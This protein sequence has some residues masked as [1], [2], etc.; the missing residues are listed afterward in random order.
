MH[1]ALLTGINLKAEI[2]DDK[3]L[4]LL[5]VFAHVIFQYLVVA[6]VVFDEDR[7]ELDSLTNKGA[8]S[9]R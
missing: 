4:G 1:D 6:G 9:F 8:E 2:P 3:L 7:F 5:G